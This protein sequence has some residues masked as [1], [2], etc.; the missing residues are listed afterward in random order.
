MRTRCHL[1][2]MHVE[3]DHG[4]GS[5][6]SWGSAK[7]VSGKPEHEGC[8]GNG[9]SGFS[10]RKVDRREKEI[11]RNHVCRAIQDKTN[12]GC[13]SVAQPKRGRL[14]PGLS[15]VL[16]QR[17]SNFARRTDVRVCAGRALPRT[18]RFL[19]HL[20][21]GPLSLCQRYSGFARWPAIV[22]ASYNRTVL[23][24]ETSSGSYCTS[25][26]AIQTLSML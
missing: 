14:C 15:F 9:P 16:C 10:C 1:G 3:A 20:P 5:L 18:Q 7:E 8:W 17:C 12:G 24:L 4:I 23:P 22:A 26:R 11:W 21:R 13:H 19:P 6:Q 2:E 25:L